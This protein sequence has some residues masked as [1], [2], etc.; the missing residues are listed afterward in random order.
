MFLVKLIP[1]L[2][3]YCKG[4]VLEILDWGLSDI[5]WTLGPPMDTNKDL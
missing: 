3:T 5:D 2:V 4:H 1:I